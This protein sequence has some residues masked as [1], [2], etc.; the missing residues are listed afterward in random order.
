VADLLTTAISLQLFRDTAVTPDNYESA[1]KVVNLTSQLLLDS[2]LDYGPFVVGSGLTV[3]LPALPSPP[4]DLL[5][6]EADSSL[7]ININ[8]QGN[9]VLT[10]ALLTFAQV[11]TCSLTNTIIPDGETV[12]VAVN[13]RYFAAKLDT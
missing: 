7:Y 13:V 12:P 9:Q 6:V 1:D 8:S 10:N 11:N 3:S 2:S 4:Y 5:L